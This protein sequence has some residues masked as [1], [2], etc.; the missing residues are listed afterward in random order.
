VLVFRL[1]EVTSR[2]APRQL[3]GFTLTGALLDDASLSEDTEDERATAEFLWMYVAALSEDNELMQLCFPSGEVA[4]E[5]VWGI[6]RSLR[7][8]DVAFRG[9]IVDLLTTDYALNGFKQNPFESNDIFGILRALDL[10]DLGQ[11]LATDGASVVMERLLDDLNTNAEAMDEYYDKDCDG[12]VKPSTELIAAIRKL[13]WPLS[14]AAQ[15]RLN[16]FRIGSDD[17]EG[18]GGFRMGRQL[19]DAYQLI[20]KFREAIKQYGETIEAAKDEFARERAA[21]SPPPTKKVRAAY[22]GGFGAFNQGGDCGAMSAVK[23]TQ[24]AYFG[25]GEAYAATGDVE[26]SLGAFQHALSII[27]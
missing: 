5:A 10:F 8:E 6:A 20:G 25:M 15:E 23:C 21:D 7:Q 9:R 14:V 17:V 24:L 4:E 27:E 19:A 11:D 26:L 22:G 13:Q 18:P 12:P 2:T 16:T 1:I 3:R